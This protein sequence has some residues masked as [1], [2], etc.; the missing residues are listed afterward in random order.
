MKDATKLAKD[1]LKLKSNVHKMIFKAKKMML[2]AKKIEMAFQ[3]RTKLETNN[4]SKLNVMDAVTG[5]LILHLC[6]AC[7][8]SAC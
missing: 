7:C 4:M 2:K 3:K 6:P 1:A 5:R 8:E